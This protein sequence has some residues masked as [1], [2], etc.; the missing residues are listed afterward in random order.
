MLWTLIGQADSKRTH[1]FCQAAKDLGHEINFVRIEDC[2]TN[3]LKGDIV[4]IDP[5]SYSS[6]EVTQLASLTKEYMTILKSL[7]LNQN[8][9]FLNHPDDILMS[10]DKRQCKQLL[11]T[12]NISTTPLLSDCDI[13]NYESLIEIMKQ[14]HIHQVFIKPNTGSGAAGVSAFRINFRKSDFI[15][16]TSILLKEGKLFNT[17]KIQRINSSEEIKEIVNQILKDEAIVEQWIPKPTHNDLGYDLRVVWQFGK[18]AFI[19]PRF[20]QSP[21]TNLHLNNKAGLFSELDLDEDIL[22]QIE[23]TCNNTMKLFPKLSYAGIDVLLTRD[24]L[25]PMVIEVNGQGD[26][27]YQDIYDKNQIYR[28]QIEDSIHYFNLDIK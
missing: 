18:M 15:L 9:R 1:F 25:K 14:N 19:V 2:N 16:Y 22:Y 17:K 3:I 5:P 7:S 27:I 11:L 24:E 4:K 12:N 13:H 8:T 26:L 20:S 23:Q 28:Q 21:I 10:L 6:S